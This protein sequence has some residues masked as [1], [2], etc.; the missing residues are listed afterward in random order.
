[1]TPWHHQ[2]YSIMMLLL[3]LAAGRCHRPGRA[4]VLSVFVRPKA[5]TVE[6]ALFTSGSGKP[7]AWMSGYF[8]CHQ[9]RVVLDH[10]RSCQVMVPISRN[11]L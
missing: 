6:R 5:L 11:H 9:G 1:M 8:R 4:E 2:R 3:P 7:A 10:D